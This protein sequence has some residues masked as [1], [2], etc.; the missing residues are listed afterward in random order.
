MLLVNNQKQR[1]WLAKIKL[2]IYRMKCSERFDFYDVEKT[3]VFHLL[4][5]DVR[6]QFKNYSLMFSGI[7]ERKTV[8]NQVGIWETFLSL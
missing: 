3:C 6:N 1:F 5:H 7:F 4:S 2:L 8:T